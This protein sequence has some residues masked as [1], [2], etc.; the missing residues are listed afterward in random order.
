MLISFV[1]VQYIFRYEIEYR[2]CRETIDHTEIE[3]LEFLINLSEWI[4]DFFL[5]QKE[6]DEKNKAQFS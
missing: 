1:Y 2:F 4:D 6:D 3:S 5:Y